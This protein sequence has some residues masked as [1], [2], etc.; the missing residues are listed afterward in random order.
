M[1]QYCY[2]D[3]SSMN[4]VFKRASMA[5][6]AAALLAGAAGVQAQC[7]TDR[8]GNSVCP[9]AGGSCMLDRNGDPVCSPPDGSITKDRYGEAVCGAG[10]CVTNRR[11]EVFCSTAARGS[12]TLDRYDE[13]V[14]TSGCAQASA[15]QCRRP[16]R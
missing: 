3:T 14:C 7:I 12:A 9:P 5:L 13:A 11:G 8:Y 1:F 15:A 4:S 10:A 16:R 6:S 2:G